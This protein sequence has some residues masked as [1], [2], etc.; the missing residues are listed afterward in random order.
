MKTRDVVTL[1]RLG[2][3]AADMG[4]SLVVYPDELAVIIRY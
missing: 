4:C 3:Q 1:K 2:I